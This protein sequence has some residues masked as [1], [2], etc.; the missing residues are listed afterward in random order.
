MNVP[1]LKQLLGGAYRAAS[2]A[3]I[4]LS[5]LIVILYICGIRAFRVR[6]GSMGEAVPLGSLCLVSTYSPYDDLR[7]G[8]VIAFRISEDISVTHR[9]VDVTAEGI[10]TQGDCNSIPDRNPVTR[11]NYIG[12]TIYAVPYLGY[13]QGWFCTWQGM[14]VLG[15]FFVVLLISG[16]IFGKEAV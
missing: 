16:R 13:V 10:I 4:A 7:A 14:T 15:T 5:C 11:E 12:K 8:D 1:I 6:S 2:A 9:A 3:V